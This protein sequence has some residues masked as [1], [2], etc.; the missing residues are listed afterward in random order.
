MANEPSGQKDLGLVLDMWDV[1][2][3]VDKQVEKGRSNQG[4]EHGWGKSSLLD[5]I[6]ALTHGKE[7]P[8]ASRNGTA[9]MTN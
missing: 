7:G 2:A 8:T 5:G 4:R 9:G 3:V 1:L 6:Q